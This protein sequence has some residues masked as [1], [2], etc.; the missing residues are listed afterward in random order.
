MNTIKRYYTPGRTV[1]GV[2]A[3]MLEQP[4]LLIAGTTGAGKSTVLSGLLYTAV[5]IHSPAKTQLILIDP[6]RIDL[7]PFKD[8]PHVVRH[9]TENRDIINT[10]TDVLKMIDTRYKIMEQSGN[11]MYNGPDTYIIID[12][13]ADL[14]TTQK[15]TILPPL[16][17]VLQI[18][19]AARVHVI[20]CTQCPLAT[21][22]PTPLK[23]NFAARLGLRTL[24]AQDSRN[25]IGIKGCESLPEHGRGIYLSSKGYEEIDVPK[26]PETD[27]QSIKEY[28]LSPECIA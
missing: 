21:V 19:R 8:L 5:T 10:L 24:S 3:N 1:P 27:I 25:I 4:H 14:M 22:I 20:A 13:I 7:K 18:A 11:I 2:Y 23:V 16:Q 28:W 26:I 15:K 12:E 9:V 17:R 6:K